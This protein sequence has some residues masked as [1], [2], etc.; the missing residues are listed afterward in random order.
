[1][2]YT[3]FILFFCQYAFGAIEGIHGSK[4]AFTH[5]SPDLGI[6]RK[7]TFSGFTFHENLSRY[8]GEAHEKESKSLKKDK[9]INIEIINVQV[10]QMHG[11]S[12]IDGRIGYIVRTKD[13]RYFLKY[14]VRIRHLVGIVPSA[15]FLT[16]LLVQQW[17]Q[18]LGVEFGP[19]STGAPYI[20]MTVSGC[21]NT[22]DEYMR[23]L[24]PSLHFRES[25]SKE[26]WVT[27]QVCPNTG[28]WNIEHQTFTFSLH[29]FNYSVIEDMSL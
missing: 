23:N 14:Q 24:P 20:P 8:I 9:E 22:M 29:T 28:A 25:P 17:R 6:K 13:G 18:R 5:R 16:K 2:K 12:T 1:M 27:V 3:L 26:I 21:D 11:P 15:G 7:V 10:I 19:I 4:N